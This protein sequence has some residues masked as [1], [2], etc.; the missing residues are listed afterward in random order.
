[1]AAESSVLAAVSSARKDVILCVDDDP[2]VLSSLRRLLRGEPYEL[3]T[4]DNPQLAME[5]IEKGGVSLV[6]MDQRMPGM[7]GSDFAER[8][9]KRSPDTLRVMLTAYP[10]NVFVHHGL[11][12]AIQWLMSKPWNDEALK[13]TLRQLLQDRARSQRKATSLR[14]R[15]AT[16]DEAKDD[17]IGRQFSVEHQVAE[18]LAESLSV[19]EACSRVVGTVARGLGWSVGL[20][21]MPDAAAGGLRMA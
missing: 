2:S 5:C 14:P 7:C 1:M 4:V 10:G 11:S 20:L 18:I 15:T 6:L 16:P 17:A 8:V 19:S 21:W 3:V 12:D 13:L 9:Q